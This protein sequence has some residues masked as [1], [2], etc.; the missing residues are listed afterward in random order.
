M[1]ERPIQGTNTLVAVDSIQFIPKPYK[2]KPAFYSDLYLKEGLSAAQIAQ[3]IGCSKT[4]VLE[5]LRKQGISNGSGR[6]TNPKNFRLH[7]PPF[8]FSKLEGSLV[9]NKA[10][11][12][13]CRLVVELR[14]RQKMSTRETAEELMRREIR[15]RRGVVYWTHVAVGRIFN[16]WKGKI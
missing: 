11:M 2:Q 4:T 6:R 1:V 8:G 13:I 15:N 14:D 12:R 3:R 10:E 9:P 7:H 5:R 16:Q